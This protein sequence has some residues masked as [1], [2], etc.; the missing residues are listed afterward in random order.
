MAFANDSNEE[1]NEIHHILEYIA[2]QIA[3][4]E[5]GFALHH[6]DIGNIRTQIDQLQKNS[7]SK[8]AEIQESIRNLSKR[9]KDIDGKYVELANK[10]NKLYEES[11]ERDETS[12]FLYDKHQEVDERLKELESQNQ[13][14]S[15]LCQRLEEQNSNLSKICQNLENQNKA[16]SAK[17]QTA[18]Q[19]NAELSNKVKQLKNITEN[20]GIPCFFNIKV[21][22]LE[23][24][25]KIVLKNVELLYPP[26]VQNLHSAANYFSVAGVSGMHFDGVNTIFYI[27]IDPKSPVGFGIG[28]RFSITG[29]RKP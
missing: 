11:K 3:E 24:H 26:M 25:H 12:Q 6:I 15:I 5:D 18:E 10:T 23:Q 27:D 16:M 19:K 13:N 22:H 21:D 20:Y 1:P 14:L 2:S 17:L 28:A 4:I 29:F 8:N 9:L 7:Y